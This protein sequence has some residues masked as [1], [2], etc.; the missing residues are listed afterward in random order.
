MSSRED[1]ER[2]RQQA[3]LLEKSIDDIE[4]EVESAIQ[5]HQGSGQMIAY[6]RERHEAQLGLMYDLGK[7]AARIEPMEERVREAE[8]RGVERLATDKWQEHLAPEDHLDWFKESL[9]EHPPQRDE[10]DIP[11]QRML[12]D[13]EREAP[14][15]HLDWLSDR[16]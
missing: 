12:D 3:L 4:Y 15:D 14:E 6:L 5:T 9:G 7:V 1:L 8:E 16:C 11:E 13:M 10:N 2:L